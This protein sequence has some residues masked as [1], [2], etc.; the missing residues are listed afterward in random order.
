M[1]I[2]VLCFLYKVMKFIL[3]V[4]QQSIIV[5]FHIQASL[6]HQVSCQQNSMPLLFLCYHIS[7]LKKSF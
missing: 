4:L 3:D 7:F 5:L 6:N 2:I 1:N